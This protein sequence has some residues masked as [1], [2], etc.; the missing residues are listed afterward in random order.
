[1]AA[2]FANPITRKVLERVAIAAGVAVT[3]WLVGRMLDAADRKLD[4]T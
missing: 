2:F 3:Q 1:M 4:E